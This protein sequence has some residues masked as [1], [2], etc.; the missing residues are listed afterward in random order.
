MPRWE[1][2]RI[3]AVQFSEERKKGGGLFSSHEEHVSSF[4]WKVERFS[5]D[6]KADYIE[7]STA[8]ENQRLS[9]A[10]VAGGADIRPGAGRDMSCPRNITECEVAEP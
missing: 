5:P 1:V 10:T 2:C 3:V 6:G 7:Q 4:V 9:G 8:W